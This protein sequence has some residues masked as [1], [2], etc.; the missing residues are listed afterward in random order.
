M[1]DIHALQPH[2]QL[3]SAPSN[4]LLTDRNAGLLIGAQLFL[5]G[6]K[7]KFASFRLFSAT[8]RPSQAIGRRPIE[9]WESKIGDL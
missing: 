9:N 7:P 8:L 4:S 6:S 5:P 2:G 1:H 3:P